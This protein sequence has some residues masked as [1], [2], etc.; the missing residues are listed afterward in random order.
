MNLKAQPQVGVPSPGVGG[1]ER[2]REGRASI[3]TFEV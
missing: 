1:D 3:R 2:R